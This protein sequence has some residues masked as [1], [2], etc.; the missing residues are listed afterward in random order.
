M[1]MKSQTA[2]ALSRGL[3]AD[4]APRVALLALDISGD[5]ALDALR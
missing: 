4:L 1:H 5:A 3:W 2:R